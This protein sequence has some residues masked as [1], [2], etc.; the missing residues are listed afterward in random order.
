M[1]AMKKQKAKALIAGESDFKSWRLMRPNESK[2]LRE[3]I[4]RWRAS[5]I[6]VPGAPGKWAVYPIKLWCEWAVLSPDQVERALPTLELDGL[7]RRE[8]HR[9]RGTTVRAFIQP[10]DLALAFLGRPQEQVVAK[11]AL[12]GAHA[13][14]SAGTNAG[15]DYTSFSSSI[16]DSKKA[17]PSFHEE[18]KGKAHAM[19]E[20]KKPHTKAVPDV[21]LV[22]GDPEMLEKIKEIK[23][24]KIPKEAKR[25]ALLKL[26]PVIEGLAEFKV[27]HP[28]DKHPDWHS[29]SPALHLKRYAKYCEYAANAENASG[30]KKPVFGTSAY[31]KFAK[32]KTVLPDVFD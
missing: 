6:R 1:T 19:K 5:T 16:T 27:W 3:I 14:I 8:R 12:A 7:I 2:L 31:G 11:A 21:D 24:S 29:W 17:S 15:T 32:Y 30:S 26:M 4:F 9:F 23:K 28:S 25:A 20:K 10:T 13:G 18:E 22:G